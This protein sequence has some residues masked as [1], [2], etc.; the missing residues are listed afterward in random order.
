MG[1][2]DISLA[3]GMYKNLLAL[4]D[5]SG[6]IGKTQERLASGKKVNSALDNPTNYFASQAALN[7]VSDLS[8]RKDGM[9]EAI[10]NG[11]AANAGLKAITS[12]IESAKGI[13]NSA[14]S[15]SVGDRAGLAAQFNV[16]LGQIDSLAGDSGY[17]GTNL[18]K[19]DNLS[20]NFNESGSS[21]LTIT[22]VDATSGA[23]GI[24]KT[25]NQDG[26]TVASGSYFSA[27]LKK[28]GSV[29]VW[30]NNSWGE[31]NVPAA[32]QSNVTAIAAGGGFVLALKSDGS[33][34]AWGDNSKGQ[35]TVP[36][37]VLRKQKLFQKSQI[38]VLTRKGILDL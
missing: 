31:S 30:G 11:D 21:N 36:V 7:R 37:L 22:G 6:K 2:S 8:D 25:S 32:A 29:A 3:A 33:V 9:S 20:I 13:A 27:A 14:H 10:R 35:T 26:N 1:I 19:N 38:A 4:K 15:A 23:L 16:M 18:L 17:R 12:L 34:V 5:T 28:D 24:A